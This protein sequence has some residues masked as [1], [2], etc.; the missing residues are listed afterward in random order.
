MKTPLTNYRW[1]VVTPF[2][3]LCYLAKTKRAAFNY[4]RKYAHKWHWTLTI[5]DKIPKRKGPC[6]WE[7]TPDGTTTETAH[8]KIIIT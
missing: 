1:H 6:R 4:A 7:M 8:H 3:K 2:N 5:I